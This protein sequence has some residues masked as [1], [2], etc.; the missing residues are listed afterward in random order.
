MISKIHLA[1]KGKLREQWARPAVALGTP[2]YLVS[3]REESWRQNYRPESENE[4]WEEMLFPI[5]P[6]HLLYLKWCDG[7]AC[8][9]KPN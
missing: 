7:T 5:Q 3:L 2:V 6:R 9:S 4:G 1:G 8:F